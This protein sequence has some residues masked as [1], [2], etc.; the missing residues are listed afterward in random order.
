MSSF[1]TH[2]FLR[3][4]CY[5]YIFSTDYLLWTTPSLNDLQRSFLFQK[6]WAFATDTTVTKGSFLV[7]DSILVVA[8]TISDDTISDEITATKEN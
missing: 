8:N 3:V 2:H 5:A 7:M 4:I 6:S 1:A